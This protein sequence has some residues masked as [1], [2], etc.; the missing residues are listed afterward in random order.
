MFHIVLLQAQA[1]GTDATG[2]LGLFIA[3]VVGVLLFTG[4]IKLWGIA[5]RALE[6]R[7]GIMRVA[8]PV[9]DDPAPA[10]APAPARVEKPRPS[11]AAVAQSMQ[12]TGQLAAPKPQDQALDAPERTRLAVAELPREAVLDWERLNPRQLRLVQDRDG[13]WYGIDLYA[14]ENMRLCG[15]SGSGKGNVQQLLAFQ[16]L[17]LGPKLCHVWF[18]DSKSGMDYRHFAPR[19]EHAKLFANEYVLDENDEPV[20][21]E[22]TGRPI[23]LFDGT[24]DDGLARVYREMNRRNRVIGDAGWV[25]IVEFNEHVAERERL[26][27][28]IA[29]IDEAASL[30]QDQKLR[31]EDLARKCRSAGIILVVATQYPTVEAIPSQVQPNLHRG[32]TLKVDSNKYSAVALGVLPGTKYPYEPAALGEPGVAIWRQP[33]G[34]FVIGRVPRM[35]PEVRQRIMA[36]L[37]QRY[38]RQQVDAGVRSQTRSGMRNADVDADDLRFVPPP[39][40]RSGVRSDF[41]DRDPGRTSPRSE[42]RSDPNLLLSLLGDQTFPEDW[43]ERH[44][45]LAIWLFAQFARGRRISP[46]DLSWREVARFLYPEKADQARGGGGYSDLAEKATRKVLPLVDS[47]LEAVNLPTSQAEAIEV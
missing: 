43:S 5:S 41:A 15:M 24:L 23:P 26:P 47:W 3:L 20:K 22:G 32:L 28:L 45:R 11:V 14:Q 38:P 17:M 9:Y 6:A 13:R 44:Q 39:Q 21:E 12:A 29:I 46:D 37:I 2:S 19:L 10:P 42:V 25:N 30:T 18:L 35:A 34:E 1:D 4:A 8:E 36:Q 33:G 16:A 7:S 31:E 40:G 27:I